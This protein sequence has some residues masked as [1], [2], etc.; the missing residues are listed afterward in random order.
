MV[1][2]HDCPFKLTGG[3]DNFIEEMQ[4]PQKILDL[5]YAE[6]HNCTEELQT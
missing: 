5:Y 3:E 1:L 2:K 6:P 4:I